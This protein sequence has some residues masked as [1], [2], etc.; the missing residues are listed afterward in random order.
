MP[1]VFVWRGVVCGACG[2]QTWNV[3]QN[4][5][6]PGSESG[7]FRSDG[8]MQKP[9]IHSPLKESTVWYSIVLY[10]MTS[11]LI[12]QPRPKCKDLSPSFNAVGLGICP[13]PLANNQHPPLERTILPSVSLLWVLG[14]SFPVGEQPTCT[15]DIQNHAT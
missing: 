8:P 14:F 6:A 9:R 2:P 15:T 1:E 7:F 13:F 12:N 3:S 4:A 5:C 10:S 11:G